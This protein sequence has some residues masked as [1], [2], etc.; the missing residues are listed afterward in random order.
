MKNLLSFLVTISL[1]TLFVSCEKNEDLITEEIA[2]TDE[3]LAEEIMNASSKVAIET[4][5]LP[6][7]IT[8]ETS[9][10]YFE[11]YIDE[12]YLIEG[13]GYEL[14]LAS[15][16]PIY[17]SK[18]GKRLRLRAAFCKADRIPISQ[19]TAG[20]V[21]YINNNY[22]NDVIKGA[23]QLNSGAY[24]VGLSS[25]TIVIFDPNGVFKKEVQ[26]LHHPCR[27]FD[28][29]GDPIALSSLPVSVA[30]YINNNYPNATPRRAFTKNGNYLVIVTQ[31]NNVYAMGFDAQGNLLFIRH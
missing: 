8:D 26:V 13:K 28:R 21:A 23:K 14:I 12:A 15:G 10:E 31:N 19:L 17:Y 11:T 9:E 2:I 5:D 1:L 24:F 29:L 25:K 27:G 7:T 18:E 3:Q 4:A 20:I 16:E 22:P 6:A 30:L